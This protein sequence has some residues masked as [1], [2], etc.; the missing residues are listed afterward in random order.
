M[1]EKL[2]EVLDFMQSRRSRPA[3][4]LTGPVPEHSEIEQ[5]LQMAA[6]SPDH[7]KLEPWRFI[8][9]EKPAMPRLAELAVQTAIKLG[10][11]PENIAR[12]PDCKK[13]SHLVC[14]AWRRLA[15]CRRCGTAGNC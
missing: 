6:R 15:R 2:S 10:K 1:P 14:F 11:P 13:P 9:L 8:V 3:K 12:R 5:L 4:I 7:K